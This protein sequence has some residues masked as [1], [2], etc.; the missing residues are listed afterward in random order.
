MKLLK[1]IQS[2]PVWVFLVAMVFPMGC[3]Q[4]PGPAKNIVCILVD[5]LRK[6]AADQWA[7]GINELATQGV[8]FDEM[9]TPAPWTYPSVISLMSGLYP[10][11]HGADGRKDNA[12]STFDERVPLIQ[13]ILDER[14]YRTAAF[15]ANPF[16]LEWNSFH[17]GFDTFD[18]HF[19]G[20]QG[21][22]R[23]KP[24]LVWKPESMFADSVNE[25]VIRHFDGLLYDAPELTYIHYIDVHGPWAGAPFAADYESAV[26]Y[27][28]EKVMEIY[29]FFNERYQGEML[30]IVTSDHGLAQGDDLKLGYG[31]PWRLNKNSVHDF[32]LRIPFYILPSAVVRA[33]RRV[34]GNCCNIDL[35]PTLLDWLDIKPDFALPGISLLAA[36]EGTGDLPSDRAVYTV[37]K[38]W[39][40]NPTD[41]IVHQGRKYMRFIGPKIRTETVRRIFDLKADPQETNPLGLEFGEA[42]AL[43]KD[44]AGMHGRSFPVRF[45]A[46]DPEVRERMKQLGYLR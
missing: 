16:L 3:R 45:E 40:R 19:I 2:A 21:N 18:S 10:Q 12:V 25:S 13:R 26:R 37:A 33:P 17:Q 24:K 9:R 28:D 42:N 36:I 14:G 30:F 11:Q 15:V 6:D 38:A 34:A 31:K 20:S 27:I 29:N 41:C 32:N 39:G 5:Q 23:G 22:Q 43:M 35:V 7:E 44:A 8:V 1:I 46:V 4:A